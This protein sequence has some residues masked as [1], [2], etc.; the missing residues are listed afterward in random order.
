MFYSLKPKMVC[1]SYRNVLICIKALVQWAGNEGIMLI[2]DLVCK[3]HLLL[4]M[5]DILQ[6]FLEIH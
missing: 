3:F 1:E 5:K 4:S 2:M 6:S